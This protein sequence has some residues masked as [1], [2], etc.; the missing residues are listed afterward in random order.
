MTNPPKASLGGMA[1]AFP[2]FSDA[3]SKRPIRSIFGAMV[4]GLIAAIMIGFLNPERVFSIL[5]SYQEN[6]LSSSLADAENARIGERVDLQIADK[7]LE[8]RLREGAA[9][10]VAR[11][12]A[13]KLDS[14]EQI[15]GVVDVFESMDPLAERSGI[16]DRRLP[17]DAIN[18]SVAFMLAD[19]NNPRCDARNRDEHDDPDLRRFLAIA[20]LESS[21]ACPIVSLDGRP[22]GLVALSSRVPLERTPNKIARV[23]TLALQLGG[24]W[25][26]SP[27]VRRAIAQLQ[28][29][30]RP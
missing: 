2:A 1:A 16:R 27:K 20:E 3:V 23:R 15:I 8:L 9:R 5:D 24:Y 17:L 26:Q 18:N 19:R 7:L 12:F 22:L 4:L 25:L 6:K 13:F 30:N 21:V 10:A 28:E 11:T 14:N 29:G